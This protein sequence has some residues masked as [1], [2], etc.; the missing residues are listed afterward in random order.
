T[1]PRGRALESSAAVGFAGSGVPMSGR[2][3]VITGVVVGA[4]AA[5]GVAWFLT[6]RCA[7]VDSDGGS[8]AGGASAAAADA[9]ERSPRL[10][11]RS[12]ASR[13][14]ETATESTVDDP[15]SVRGR[16]VDK[17]GKPLAAIVLVVR[18]FDPDRPYPGVAPPPTSTTSDRAGRFRID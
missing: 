10:A 6:S 11:G 16:V 9:L 5:A 4:I 15:H 3:R 13:E 8:D 7:T 1:E 12:V 14:P 18:S 17:D 2:A